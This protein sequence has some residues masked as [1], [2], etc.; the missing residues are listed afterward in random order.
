M[1]R[2]WIAS[3]ILLAILAL[4]LI[5]SFYI[6]H[7]TADL[8]SLLEQ[9]ETQA[10]A[11]N[12]DNAMEYNEQAHRRWEKSDA[13]LHVLLRHT[14]TDAVYTSFH[15]VEEFLQCQE[16]GEYSAANAKLIVQLELLSEAEQLTL[17][18]VL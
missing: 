18:N 9:A 3:C 17:K 14:D 1:K 10:E 2:I 8:I 15:E 7:F 6:A 5:H 16:G 12:W 11:G 13:Y 4:T